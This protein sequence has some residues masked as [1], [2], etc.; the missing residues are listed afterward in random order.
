MPLKNI[1]IIILLLLSSIVNSL[2]VDSLLLKLKTKTLALDKIKY[3]LE[4]GR[5]LEYNYPDSAKIFYKNALILSK[6]IKNDTLEF[7]SLIA[8]GYTYES[9]GNLDSAEILYKKALKISIKLKRPLEEGSSLAYLGNIYYYKGD[10]EKTL[11]YYQKSLEISE[12]YDDELNAANLLHNIGLV[13]HDL[14]N[15]TRG[16]NYYEK[17]LKIFKK[18]KDKEWLSTCYNSIG[19][20]YLELKRFDLAE[21]NY[22]KSLQNFMSLGDKAGIGMVLSN[23]GSLMIR[24]NKVDLA[25][26]YLTRSLNLSKEVNDIISIVNTSNNLADLFLSQKLYTKSLK[27]A[28]NA[29]NYAHEKD[30][31]PYKKQSYFVIKTASFEIGDYKTSAMYADSLRI[32]TDTLLNKEQFK[33]V[34]ELEQKYQSEKKQ[35]VITNLQKDQALQNEKMQNQRIYIFAFIFIFIIILAFTAFIL[36]LLRTKQKTNLLLSS[37]QKTILEKNEELNQLIEEVTSQ[38]D[39]IEMQKEKLFQIHEDVTQSIFYAK[40]IQ[41]SILPNNELFV[42]NF[43]EHFILY[44]PKDIVSGD[45]YWIAKIDNTLVLTL[46][47]CT[48]HGVPGAFMSMLGTSLLREII[49]KEKTIE[50]SKILN[51]LRTEV[52]NSLKQ[53][54]EIGEHK[55]GMDMAIISINLDTLIASYAGANN[56]IYIISEFK[57]DDFNNTELSLENS[58]YFSEIK[59]NKMPISHF[60]KMKNFETKT[61][62][63]HKNDQIYLFS[64]GYPDQFG[65]INNRKFKY[66]QFKELIFTNSNKPFNEQKDIFAKTLDIWQGNNSQVDDITVLG[67][68]I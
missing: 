18:Y 48:G 23:L 65:G 50:P 15:Y 56:P 68:K 47:D 62:Q 49:V 51:K 4:I 40:Q 5:L 64:D 34:E 9:T 54:G 60:V 29:L 22:Q 10:Y 31:L 39:E 57:I 11:I 44:K 33:N 55:D 53:T 41:N 67:V 19:S 63:L 32:L 59:S 66:K 21:E 24:Q 6:Q 2:T 42:N 58:K 46:A 28:K 52:I 43:S 45:F 1:I 16:L 14:K 35:L 61:I 17:A 26:N 38:K 7:R 27:Y 13:H 25:E 12:K 36:K 37:Q 20:I 30:I 8:L 3:N